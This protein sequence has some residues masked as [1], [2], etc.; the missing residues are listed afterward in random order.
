MRFANDHI[1]RSAEDFKE[2]IL[3]L[4]EECGITDKE[5]SSVFGVSMMTISRWENQLDESNMPAF[6]LG[7]FP[8]EKKYQ[9][10]ALGFLKILA[11]RYDHILIRNI[12]TRELNGNLT[13]EVMESVRELGAISAH[14][15]IERDH[16]K[17][18]T[19]HAEKLI[20]EGFRM[21]AE[22]KRKTRQ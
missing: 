9:D 3:Q 13:D 12:E 6:V 15:T 19:R 16:A 18:L 5:L 8:K 17:E 4:E 2:L 14:A 7:A 10:F 1:R 11:S 21:I 22:I 20:Q